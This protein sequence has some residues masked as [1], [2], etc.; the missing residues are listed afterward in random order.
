MGLRGSWNRRVLTLNRF[1]EK[2]AF[3]ISSKIVRSF[4]LLLFGQ[5]YVNSHIN[6]NREIDWSGNIGIYIKLDEQQKWR[7]YN[8]SFDFQTDFLFISIFLKITQ[9]TNDKATFNCATRNCGILLIIEMSRRSRLPLE[10]E[11]LWRTRASRGINRLSVDVDTFKTRG[12]RVA[13][14]ELRSWSNM[15]A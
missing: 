1:G 15:I 4:V 14:S 11:T 8:L 3:K 10:D 7:M 6:E 5:L 9:W 12:I 2:T 13:L